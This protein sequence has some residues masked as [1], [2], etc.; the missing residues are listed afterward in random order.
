MREGQGLGPLYS[1]L[2]PASSQRTS[3]LGRGR[4]SGCLQIQQNRPS[5]LSKVRV[6][7]LRVPAGS[8]PAGG[9]GQMLGKGQEFLRTKPQSKTFRVQQLIWKQGAHWA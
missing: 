1:S 2:F 6:N 3:F 8:H 4:K 9:L 7:S 5:L